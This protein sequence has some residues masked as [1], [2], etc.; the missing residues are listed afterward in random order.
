MIENAGRLL[1]ELGRKA[2]RIDIGAARRPPLYPA[3]ELRT[4]VYSYRSA[5]GAGEVGTTA[6]SGAAD[7]KSFEGFARG[8][9]GAFGCSGV[10]AVVHAASVLV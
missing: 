10:V 9:V 1:G 8:R 4:N 6:A 2:T 5:P 7:D 3:T